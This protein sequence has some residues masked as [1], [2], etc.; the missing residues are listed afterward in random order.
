MSKYKAQR[1]TVSITNG[2]TNS[3]AFYLPPGAKSIRVGLSAADAAATYD[4]QAFYGSVDEGAYDEGAGGPSAISTDW[5]DVFIGGSNTTKVTIAG[6]P[7]RMSMLDVQGD[8]PAML[9][10]GWYRFQASVGVTGDKS[11]EVVYAM[12]FGG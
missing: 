6:T 1:K 4:L 11:F 3:T 10:P 8:S 5:V 12:P 7:V 2:A 9:P